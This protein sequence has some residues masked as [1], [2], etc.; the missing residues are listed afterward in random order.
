MISISLY[1]LF[2][3]P[4]KETIEEYKNVEKNLGTS[5]GKKMKGLLMT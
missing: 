3:G 5:W 2:P 4:K 1:Y